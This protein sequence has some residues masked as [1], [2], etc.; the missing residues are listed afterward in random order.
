MSDASVLVHNSCFNPKANA[1]KTVKLDNG[2]KA[3][4]QDSGEYAG[5]F[6][7][8]DLAR[9]GNSAYKL[10]EP[11]GNKSVR[12]LG[13]LA[14]DGARILAKHSS[15]AGKVYKIVKWITLK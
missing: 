12:L 11:V 5:K 4:L 1:S 3:Y 14:A 7:S 9:H 6:I 13:D 15:N 10:F 2:V 8:K